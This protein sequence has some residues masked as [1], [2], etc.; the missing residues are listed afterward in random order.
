M[1]HR[2]IEEETNGILLYDIFKHYPYDKINLKMSRH[3]FNIV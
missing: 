1:K 2:L 3:N